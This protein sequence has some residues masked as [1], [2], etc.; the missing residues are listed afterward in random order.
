MDCLNG[1]CPPL[2]DQ[3]ASTAL[4]TALMRFPL[5]TREDCNGKQSEGPPE[6]DEGDNCILS[7]DLT[8]SPRQGSGNSRDVRRARRAPLTRA[9]A[10]SDEE[11]MMSSCGRPSNTSRSSSTMPLLTD[12][13]GESVAVSWEAKRRP[14]MSF[15]E[16]ATAPQNASSRGSAFACTGLA[17]GSLR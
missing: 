14:T 1:Q 3:E 9:R 8:R 13:A 4:N 12:A 10:A 7:I 6:G 2:S 15:P 5:A 11:I 17:A 16:Q